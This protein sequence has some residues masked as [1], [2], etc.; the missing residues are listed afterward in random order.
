MTDGDAGRV[1]DRA[2]KNLVARQIQM[3][4]KM[5]PVRR[6]HDPFVLQ[7]RIASLQFAQEHCAI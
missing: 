2:V 5:V 3:A 4:S 7:L 6:V 1:V